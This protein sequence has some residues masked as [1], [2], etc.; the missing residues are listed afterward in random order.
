MLEKIRGIFNN[1]IHLYTAVCVVQ[2]IWLAALA[3]DAMNHFYGLTVIQVFALAVNSFSLYT[4][5]KVMF[6]SIWQAA[7]KHLASRP[8]A[9]KGG[10]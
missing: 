5:R 3:Y 9:L 8:Q 10:D 2:G 6:I 7:E 4:T 1:P